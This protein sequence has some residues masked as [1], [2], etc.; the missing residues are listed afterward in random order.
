MK[1]MRLF[2]GS[3]FRNGR[4][5][6][7]QIWCVLFPDILAP[8][9]QIWSR[10]DQRSWSYQQA[11]NRILFFVLIYSCCTHMPHFLGL[12]DSYVSFSFASKLLTCYWHS[13]LGYVRFSSDDGTHSSANVASSRQIFAVAYIQWQ[14]I[15]LSGK[16]L[17]KPN[18]LQSRKFAHQEYNLS[19]GNP[20]T[21]SL[22]DLGKSKCKNNGFV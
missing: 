20:V 17:L 1:K 9:Q 10:L 18:A 6:L 7:L 2:E 22:H 3:H 16:F 13:D 21:L 4:L 12:L 14:G 11:Y 8:A 5:D 15:F 19:W